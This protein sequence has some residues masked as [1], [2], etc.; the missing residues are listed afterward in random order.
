LRLLHRIVKSI[1]AVVPCE[2]VLGVKLNAAD[3]V[4]QD[5]NM[6]QLSDNEILALHHVREMA[7]WE[8]LDFIEVSGGGKKLCYCSISHLRIYF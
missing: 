5:G 1:R 7:T 8:G 4:G 6:T 3:Y 2:F